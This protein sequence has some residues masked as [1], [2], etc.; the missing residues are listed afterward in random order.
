VP[1]ERTKAG[2][3]RAQ[4]KV[5]GRP[6]GYPRWR[7]ELRAMRDAGG[8][9]KV[10]MARRTGLSFNTL[11]RYLRRIEAEEAET[12]ARAVNGTG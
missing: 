5:L 10:E 7:E 2:L 8:V 1:R 11:K 4:G 6:D 9:S 3:E 12:V